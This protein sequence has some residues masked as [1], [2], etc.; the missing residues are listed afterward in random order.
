MQEL[1]TDI[2]RSI[3]KA[4][5]YVSICGIMPSSFPAGVPAGVQS[6]ALSPE[7]GISSTFGIC[8]CSCS[9]SSFI[10]PFASA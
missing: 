8:A 2:A 10:P 1:I 9:I 4:F 5:G 6:P 7:L 3:W